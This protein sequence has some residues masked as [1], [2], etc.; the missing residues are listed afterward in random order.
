MSANDIEIMERRKTHNLDDLYI[1]PGN[2][3]YLIGSQN[4]LFPDFGHHVEGEMGGIWNHPIKLLDGYWVKISNSEREYWL[5]K[6]SEYIT[7]PYYNKLI[8]SVE[9]FNIAVVRREFCPDD[10]Q[11]YVATF[12]IFN[13]DNMKKKIRLHFVGKTD[14][15]GVW[16]SELLGI[17]D[18]EDYA[19]YDEKLDAIIAKDEINPWY[20]VFGSNIK[21]ENRKIQKYNEAFPKTKGK[22]IFGHF[23]YEFEI[24]SNST[25][26]I[27]FVI[28][29]SYKSKEDCL[30]TY[31]KVKKDFNSMLEKKRER[32]KNLININ[33]IDIPDSEYKSVFDW[34]KINYD[35]L[36]REVPE[37]GKGI[38]AGVPE[39]PWWFEIDS[40]YAIYGALAVGQFEICKDT[41]RLIKQVSE[42]A[43]NSNGRVIHEVSTNGVVNNNGNTQETAHFVKCVYDIFE[44]TGDVDF[45]KEMY[46]FCRKGVLQWILGTMDPDQDLLPSGYG[47]IE[48]EHLNLEMIDS[49]VYTCEALHALQK[50]AHILNDLQ[51]FNTAKTLGEKLFTQINNRFW[52]EEEGLYAD[53][54]ATSYQM[55]DRLDKFIEYFKMKKCS[56]EKLQEVDELKNKIDINDLE[57]EKNWLLKNW[58]ILT[59]IESGIA[60][61]NNALRQLQRMETK[62][63]TNDYG[64]VL[65]GSKKTNERFPANKEMCNYEMENMVMSISTGVMAVAEAQYGRIDKAYEYMRK[66]ASSIDMA[67]PGAISEMSPDYG[68]FVQAWSGYGIAWPLIRYIFGIKPEAHK[69]TIYINPQLP[70]G[71]KE[72]SI[73]NFRVGNELFEFEYK[74]DEDEIVMHAKGGREK[75]RIYFDVPALNNKK[76]VLIR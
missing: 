76:V 10:Y 55:Q 41:L 70:Q 54:I 65:M 50:M 23:E 24:D 19:Y 28:A 51:T 53:M 73:K 44:W 6:A 61:Y 3:V 22:G 25:F 21:S 37:I 49:A 2:R 52:L 4:G 14:L 62:E 66:I 13:N 74:E 57:K 64:I 34:V 46:T 15:L 56:L 12:Q 40:T 30:I 72:F 8:F 16:N 75:W 31:N 43:N 27:T 35:M 48:I 67:M 42:K 58:I 63:F 5:G 11:A 1:C 68:C 36:V 45:L 33:K 69:K 60:P 71:W 17:K 38:G 39:Y 29:G 59:P 32:I 18:G 9:D 26:D 20:A 47:I 7:G